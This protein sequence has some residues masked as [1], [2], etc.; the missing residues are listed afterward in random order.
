M[1]HQNARHIE[2]E[3]GA[4]GRMNGPQSLYGDTTDTPKQAWIQ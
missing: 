2:V 1:G 3:L 4:R